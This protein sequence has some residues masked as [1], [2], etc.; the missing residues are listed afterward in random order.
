MIIITPTHSL[1]IFNTTTI[2]TATFMYTKW[3]ESED[4]LWVCGFFFIFLKQT[5]NN[6]VFPDD[7][8]DRVDRVDIRQNA[9]ILSQLLVG[10]ISL[11]FILCEVTGQTTM[12][13]LTHDTSWLD[14]I[15]KQ[16]TAIIILHALLF[17]KGW[18][19]TWT[20]LILYVD[21]IWDLRFWNIVFVVFQ[22][23]ETMFHITK[24]LQKLFRLIIHSFFSAL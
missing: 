4:W 3:I 5:T 23:N 2:E 20:I 6:F 18:N 10:W 9:W 14:L 21:L 16:Q 12:I 15:R 24:N 11:H 7:S 22:T 13:L 19:F 1:L 17:I 8:V